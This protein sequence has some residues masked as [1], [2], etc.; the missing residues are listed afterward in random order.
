MR[1]SRSGSVPLG[2]GHIVCWNLVAAA[3]CAS[4]LVASTSQ[5]AGGIVEINQTTALSGGVNG[6][7]L[8]DPA[9]FPVVLSEPGSYLL[10]SDLV[11]ADN[12]LS[13]VFVAA[14]DITLD[15]GGF[16]IRGPNLGWPGIGELAIG[17]E[18]DGVPA[19]RLIR[20]LEKG[21]HYMTLERGSGDYILSLI[22]PEAF[23][24]VNP[25]LKRKEHS[26]LFEY[27]V[28]ESDSLEP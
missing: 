6:D 16:S 13:A 19:G 24:D 23:L 27:L 25:E 9:G 7:I 21:G 12:F 4:C 22:P 17:I 26:R 15:L 20:G 28:H 18:I 5:G 3:F 11:V 2:K 8:A 1:L 14:D 10:T